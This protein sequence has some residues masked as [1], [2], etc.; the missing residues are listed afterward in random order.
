MQGAI[1]GIGTQRGKPAIFAWRDHGNG[2][3]IPDPGVMITEATCGNTFF[4]QPAFPYS[5]AQGAGT[6]LVLPAGD[7]WVYIASKATDLGGGVWHYEYAVENLNSDRGI[8]SLRINFPTGSVITNAESR[9]INCHSGVAADD[10]NRNAPWTQTVSSDNI[11][12]STPHTYSAATPQLGSYLRWG[13]M[14]NF[15]F[16]ANVAPATGGN[17]IV[18]YFKPLATYADTI[19]AAAHVPGTVTPPACYAN[20]DGV[21]GLTAN[22]FACYLNA[23]SQGQSYA[24]CDG[25]GGLTPN[26]FACFLNSYSN[27]CS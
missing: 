20:C 16:D 7:G 24:N 23:Y 6:T 5:G 15:R 13:T 11:M 12:W 19:N 10:T 26:D 3:N 18:G 25:V 14:Y 4:T 1:G 17:A 27:G 9:Q 8:G 22:D 21:G 2:A